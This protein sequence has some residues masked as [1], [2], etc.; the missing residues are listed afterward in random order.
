MQEAPSW[1][2]VM[3]Q[4]FPR[5]QLI[6]GGLIPLGLFYLWKHLE[7]PLTG[8]LLAG[9]WG[10]GVVSF[11]V[12]RSRRI[13]VF[14]VL[15]AILASVE[16]IV[17][18]LTHSVTWYLAAAAIE[19][20]MLGGVFLLS[21]LL[22][23]SL[24]QILAEETVG[25]AT[26]SSQARQSPLYQRVWR[27]LTSIWGGV[28]VV[29]ACLLLLA[30]WGLSLEAFLVLRTL[31]GVPLWGSLLAF[32]FWFPGRY[33]RRRLGD[34]GNSAPSR[35]R[36]ALRLMIYNDYGLL[37][38]SYTL[39][40]VL[41]FQPLD[42]PQDITAAF[43][44][45]GLVFFVVDLGLRFWLY[46]RSRSPLDP[47]LFVLSDTGGAQFLCLP[48]W[49]WG[50]VVITAIMEQRSLLVPFGITL[51]FADLWY[52]LRSA[53]LAQRAWTSALITAPGSFLPIWLLAALLVMFLH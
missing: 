8:A 34:Q 26:F 41:L 1:W 21:L 49:L 43:V 10:L 42:T 14:A 24:I 44:Y 18:L 27:L 36:G 33:W 45:I 28:Y 20:G 17:T 22:P 6:I 15:A 19:S 46:R 9:L 11:A 13:N 53:R 12:W 29:K 40:L 30:Q 25:T 4:K 5:Q 47:I 38:L 2:Q 52:R 23:R 32:S 16:L 7:Q 39:F 48:L 50:G 31:L 35:E 37:L 51:G 3:Q